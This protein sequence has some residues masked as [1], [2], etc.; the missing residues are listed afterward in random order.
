[1]HAG[2]EL[3]VVVAQVAD[4]ELRAGQVAEDRHLAA[5]R[6]GR[7]ADRLDRLRVFVGA[8]VG[9]VEAEDVGAG[10]DQLLEHAEVP[11]GRADRGD[12][13][14]APLEV[15][16]GLGEGIAGHLRPRVVSG[17]ARPVNGA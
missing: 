17:G 16:G 4:A 8:G 10:G 3:G 12:D 2:L 15:S 5:E 14:G 7:L 6:G 1:M 11:R 9:E 13:L